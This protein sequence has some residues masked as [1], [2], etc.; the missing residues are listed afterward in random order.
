MVG[1]VTTADKEKAHVL[2]AFFM[3]VFKIRP[4]IL[5]VLYPLTW[6]PRMESRINPL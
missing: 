4:I 6:K 5:R 3:S 2:N 1:N